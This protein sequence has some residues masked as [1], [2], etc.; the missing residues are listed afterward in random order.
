MSSPVPL[1][2]GDQLGFRAAMSNLAAGVVVVTVGG[3][4]P[5]GVT[6]NSVTSV[7][8]RPP[9]LLACIA[10]STRMHQA[11]A[12]NDRFAVSVLGADQT[13]VAQRFADRHRPEGHAQF[14]TIPVSEGHLSGAPLIDNALAWIECAIA[15]MLTCGDHVVVLAD[16][17][18]A[19]D[20]NAG[21][22]AAGLAYF[23]SYYNST[24]ACIEAVPSL[25]AAPDMGVTR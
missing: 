16:V 17:L 3:D 5:H 7:S 1:E 4:C 19:V 25:A 12:R 21:A 13:E 9:K 6:A 24:L 10:T 15:D 18:S 14:S 23:R 20:L 8:L 2:S 22:A 11:L